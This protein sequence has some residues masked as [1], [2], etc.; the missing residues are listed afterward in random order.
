MKLKKAFGFKNW[1]KYMLIALVKYYEE[2]PGESSEPGFGL[3]TLSLGVEAGILDKGVFKSDELLE[4]RQG[5]RFVTFKDIR[6]ADLYEAV[7]LMKNRGWIWFKR[8]QNEICWLP[9]P[10][11][12]DQARLFMQPFYLRI[13]Y[14]VLG[15][16][17]T[18]IVSAITTVVTY[19]LL[20]ILS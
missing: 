19:F 15:D 7:N 13:G 12:L 20:K 5:N 2:A 3:D 4:F 1:P 8:E 10:S 6:L 18:I 16:L 17:R 9:T 14:A 11:G